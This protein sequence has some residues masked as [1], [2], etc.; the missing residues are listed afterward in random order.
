MAGESINS[1]RP[2]RRAGTTFERVMIKKLLNNIF[3]IMRKLK[4]RYLFILPLAAVL[5]FALWWNFLFFPNDFEMIKTEALRESEDKPYK[6]RSYDLLG[7]INKAQLQGDFSKDQIDKIIEDLKSRDFFI[8]KDGF[9]SGANSNIIHRVG[10]GYSGIWM[11]ERSSILIP[12]GGRI[13]FGVDLSKFDE[14]DFSFISFDSNS[15][16]T[17]EIIDGNKIKE[18]HDYT[19]ERYIPALTAADVK[20]KF[21]N[22]GFPKAKMDS[23]WADER[24][25]ITKDISN[26]KHLL[27]FSVP[28]SSGPVFVAN[29]GIYTQAERKRYNVI[30]ILLID[31]VSQRSLSFHNEKSGMTPFIKE[32]ADKDYIVFDNVVSIGNKTRPSLSGFLTSK[33]ST[34]TRHGINRNVIPQEEKELFYSLVS[35]GRFATLPD[36]FRKNGYT[37]VQFDSVGFTID[38]MGTGVDYGFEKSYS[39]LYRPYDTY[40]VSKR[41]F[42]FLRENRDKNFFVFCHYNTTNKPFYA[43]LKNYIKG[44]IAAPF[45]TLWR[46]HFTGNINYADDLYR[47]IHAMLKK[48]N[49][50]ENSIIVIASDH[51]SGYELATFDGGFHYNDFTKQVF[52]IHIPEPLKK[53]FNIPDGRRVTYI[54]SINIVPTL[55]EL[56][57]LAATDKFSGKSFLPVL[58]NSYKE[59]MWDDIIWTIGRKDISMTTPDLK[60]YILT[61]IDSDRFV[62][63]DYIVFG[64][65]Y[66]K[67][68]ELLYDLETDPLERNNLVKTDR[69][70][71]AKMR[72]IFFGADVHHPEKTVLTLYP[73]KDKRS[74]ITINI[75]SS[76]RLLRAELYNGE[77]N[78]IKKFSITDKNSFTFELDKEPLYFIFEHEND[79][80]S[81]SID[82]L[83]DGKRLGKS[84]IYATQLD[85]NI[86]DNPVKLNTIEDFRI[87]YTDK[88]PLHKEWRGNDAGKIGVKISRVDLHRWIDI[89]RA[90][91]KGLSA[92]MKET[93]KSWGYIQ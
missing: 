18:R 64:N 92:S 81:V 58:Q 62:K 14:I 88:L 20:M 2:P 79:R 89:N 9:S 76:S 51:G 61:G 33:I 3:K 72:K 22:R 52:M 93:L 55:T 48:N 19:I 73:D 74:N 71:L 40:G 32:I 28:D 54:S 26:K 53:E 15:L 29:P 82:I 70:T 39:F 38:L 80:A 91:N 6:T 43:P 90:G 68:Y 4:L 77:I 35:Q 47:N 75:N 87:L 46:P 36:Y 65:E 45:V 11:D 56:T 21:N 67:A 41:F 85:L 23:G 30:Y 13:T 84:S 86:F 59:K 60:K 78:L 83:T 49:L 7:I 37:A 16:L 5:I 31:G 42:A 66:E 25:A 34:E 12:P 69:D 8:K 63:R 24:I 50:L 1:P 27:T 44:V 10:T 57:G 17:V